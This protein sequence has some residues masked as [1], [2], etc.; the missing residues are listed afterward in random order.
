MPSVAR[1]VRSRGEGPEEITLTSMCVGSEPELRGTRMIF[2]E[3][4][5]GWG[6]RSE[7]KRR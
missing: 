5:V 1:R 6:V 3:D 7:S 2:V 4:I